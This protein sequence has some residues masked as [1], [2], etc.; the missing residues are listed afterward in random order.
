MRY[1]VIELE[2][3]SQ[4]IR[5]L[6]ERIDERFPEA[7]L[8]RVCMR[9]HAIAEHAGERAA[10]FSRPIGWLRLL[11]AGVIVLILIASIVA[12]FLVRPTEGAIE[13]AEFAQ[14]L[15]AAINDLVL[16][17]IAVFFLVTLETRL[18]RR[19]VLVAIHE[20]RAVAHIID[21]HQLTKDPERVRD[22]GPRTD[23]SPEVRL[24]RFQLGRY[25]DYC[26]EMLSLTGKIAAVYAQ[27]FPD[28]ASLAAANEV[29]NLCTGLSRK[30]WQKINILQILGETNEQP[31]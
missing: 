27:A 21:M 29:E 25:L 31:T 14:G 6:G 26:S 17:G 1:D 10:T 9:L 3:V 15:E 28:S 7:G 19:Q 4:T 16:I 23:S 11:A 18:K 30:I 2:K 12:I 13:L 8:H 5:R 20:L 22:A 24:T